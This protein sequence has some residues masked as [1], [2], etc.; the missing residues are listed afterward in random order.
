MSLGKTLNPLIRNGSTKEYR[1]LS[2]ET[3]IVDLDLKHQHK[4]TKQMD[5]NQRMS[6]IGHQKY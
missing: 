4:Q 2:H 3:K 6:Q 5:V 1:K